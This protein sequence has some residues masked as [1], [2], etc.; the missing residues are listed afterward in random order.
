MDAELYR[1]HIEALMADEAQ[2]LQQLQTLLD[3]EH[4][5][6]SNDDLEALEAAGRDRESCVNQLMRIDAERQ[7]LCRST[8]RSGDK[9]GLLSLLRWCD[10]SGR[11]QQ[12]WK[13]ST[14]M[15]R[16]CRSLNDRNGA[17][18]NNRMKRVE[19][20]L[21]A[22]NGPQASSSRTYTNRGNAYLQN[23]AGRVCSIQA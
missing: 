19:G 2:A 14:D 12:H 10:P 5:F 6:I 11:L 21:D 15:I 9:A 13:A 23:S 7:N 20:M 8:G 3:R 16:Q 18:V 4:Q 1:S 22:L 17:L